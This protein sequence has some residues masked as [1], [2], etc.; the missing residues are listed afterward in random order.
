MKTIS[1]EKPT[2][3]KTQVFTIP[4]G[5]GGNMD[6]SHISKGECVISDRLILV[7]TSADKYELKG[8]LQYSGIPMNLNILH[9]MLCLDKSG[10]LDN[11][12]VYFT[13]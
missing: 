6:Y 3:N 13:K 4:A 5:Y 2:I 8:Y 10:I 11:R 1:M 12:G 7:I 9:F